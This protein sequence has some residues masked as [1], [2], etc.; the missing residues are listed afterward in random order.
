[1]ITHHPEKGSP[2]GTFDLERGGK[3]VG[4]LSYSVT[5]DGTMTIH[6]VEVAP[7]LRGTG[8]GNQ[9]VGAAVEFARANK[10]RVV[11]QCGYAR[12]VINRTQAYQ[13]VLKN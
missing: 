11:P 5:P 2:Q 6:Y 4:Y 7:S 13:D 8:L 1:V 10:Y 3:R 12:A 9:L